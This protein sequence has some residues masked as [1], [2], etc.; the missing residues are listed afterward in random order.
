[1]S[2]AAPPFSPGLFASFLL[3]PVPD[4]VLNKVLA[5]ALR[6]VLTAHPDAFN[7][8]P[9]NSRGIVVVSLTDLQLDLALDLSPTTPALRVATDDD[10]AASIASISGPMQTLID[11]ME[12]RVDG[13]A[14]FFSRA[15]K[16]EGDTEIVVALRNTL[17]G[18]DIQIADLLPV[19][20]IISGYRPRVARL[21]ADIHRTASQDLETIRSAATA[22]LE[23]N[24]RQQKKR[25]I[26]LENRLHDLELKA[27]RQNRKAKA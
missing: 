18:I 22:G 21:L 11:L 4:V 12:G 17:D 5:W 9:E 23:K 7:R 15:L 14:L 6:R 1:M 20:G 8:L 26:E 16:F 2:V 27:A 10:R 24:D 13:D 19:P 25:I 3:R